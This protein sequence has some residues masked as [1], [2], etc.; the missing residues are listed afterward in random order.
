MFRALDNGLDIVKGYGIALPDVADQFVE[1]IGERTHIKT[2][3][4][5]QSCIRLLLDCFIAL[6]ESRSQLLLKHRRLCNFIGPPF[7][8][9]NRTINDHAMRA[10]GFKKTSAL[11]NQV[12]CNDQ[13]IICGEFLFDRVFK[14]LSRVLVSGGRAVLLTSEKELMRQVLRSYPQL[15][16][17]QEVL[18]GVLGQAARIYVLEKP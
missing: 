18:V 16:R 1:V 11:I 6:F 7:S 15:V 14:Q 3:H 9:R 8:F 12:C 2:G 10:Y 13:M 17:K 5:K 4:F